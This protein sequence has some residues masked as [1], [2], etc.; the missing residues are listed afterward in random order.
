LF[1]TGYLLYGRLAVGIV[2]AAVAGVAAFGLWRTIPKV[3]F[4]TA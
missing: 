3:G 1:A 4:W 2:C